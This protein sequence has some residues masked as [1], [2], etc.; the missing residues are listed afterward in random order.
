M[1]WQV[2]IYLSAFVAALGLTLSLT[3]LCRGIAF[4]AGFMDCPK[5]EQHKGHRRATP[6]LGGAAMLTAWLLTLGAGWVLA[7]RGGPELLAQLAPNVSSVL[8]EWQDHLR[9][10]VAVAPRL[11][12]LIAAAVLL[13]I[14]GAIDD[15]WPLKASTKFFCQLIAA[16][17]AVVFGDIRISLF[18]ESAYVTIPVTVFWYLLLFNA[19]NFFDNMDGLAVGTIAIAMGLFALVAGI[20]Q[21]YF[22]AAFAAVNC[23]VCGGFWWYNRSPATIFMGDSGS[24]F[25]GF[26]AATTSVLT[27]YYHTDNSGSR[28]AV[29]IPVFILAVPLFD[30]LAVVVIRWKLGKPFWIGDHN[31]ISHRFV[32]M[33]LTRPTAVAMVHLLALTLG[34]GVL[35][36]LWGSPLTAAIL[37]GQGALLLLIITTLQIQLADPNND[38]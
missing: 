1:S 30:T 6:L 10:L 4:R 14:M 18:V 11:A 33:G 31:H 17:I 19:I 20:N 34:L 28:F 2:W 27:S 9:G 21:Q 32:K 38:R 8:F 23:G 13:V 5:S 24:H 37:V 7:R 12:A 22:V 16:L 36:L 35:P 3:P 26:L 29:L 25:L 15:K